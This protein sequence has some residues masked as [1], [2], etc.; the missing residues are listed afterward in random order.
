MEAKQAIK[1]G[2]RIRNILLK[3]PQQSVRNGVAGLQSVR[4]RKKQGHAP[5]SNLSA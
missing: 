5:L 3:V 1:Y 4:T 2:F